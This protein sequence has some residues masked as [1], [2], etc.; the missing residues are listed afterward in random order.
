MRKVKV[1]VG[2]PVEAASLAGEGERSREEI[3]TPK[4]TSKGRGEWCLVRLPLF[5][6]KTELVIRSFGGGREKR[7]DRAERVIKEGRWESMV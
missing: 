1:E 4:E 6:S 2:F 7:G 3:D 5:S